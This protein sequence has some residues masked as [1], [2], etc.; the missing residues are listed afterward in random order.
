MRKPT[1]QL[2]VGAIVGVALIV[3]AW[4]LIPGR[5]D[6]LVLSDGVKT[7]T[8]EGYADGICRFDGAAIPRGS[9]YFIGLD[10]ELPAPVPR[11]SMRDE[12]HLR[13]GS[14]HPGPLVSI[15]ATRVVTPTAVHPRKDVAWIWLTPTISG[16]NQDLSAADVTNDEQ[17]TYLWEGRIEVDNVFEGRTLAMDVHGRHKWRG[18]Y[19]VKF[20]EKWIKNA[21]SVSSLSGGSLR[22][23]RVNEIAPLEMSYTI[24][25][26]HHHEYDDPN[27]D[28]TLRGQAGG[29]IT[30]DELSA[31]LGGSVLRFDTPVDATNTSSW[32]QSRSF[33]SF[34]E[35][36]E[37]VS[38]FYT[39]QNRQ[40][41]YELSIAFGGSFEHGTVAEQRQRYRGIDRGG[42]SPIHPD[43]DADFLKNLPG[44]MPDGANLYGCLDKPEQTEVRGELVFPTDTG[45]L[46]NP[47]QISIK[48]SFARSPCR[49][50]LTCA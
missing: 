31:V 42:S 17:P 35:Y 21:A 20:L 45:P 16:S 33:A 25:A 4:A 41:C 49:T 43:P 29:K 6:M 3:V 37:F 23:F 48:W 26:D 27:G 44:Y 9:I 46:N 22:S 28:I 18:V 32:T 12:V 47:Q 13:A 15:D 10:A 38:H 1:L 24:H 7:G 11:D 39:M 8:V 50:G 40:G 19:Q 30:G 34:R 36:E 5:V 14:I 2:I